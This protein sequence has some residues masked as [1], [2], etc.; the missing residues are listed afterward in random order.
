MAYSNRWVL[1]D[2][3]LNDE[4]ITIRYRDEVE[5]ELESGK[6]G[7]CV[8]ILWNADQVDSETGYPSTEELD[9]IDAFNKK[10]MTA[11]E[12]DAHGLLVM[13]LMS[14]GVNQWILY[15]RDN[16]EMQ[17][18][19]NTIPTDTGLYPIEVTTDADAQWDVFTQLR[20]AIKTH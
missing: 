8:Q 19:L 10:L 9:K 5:G 15:V 13:V 3:T 17:A 14:Q 7:Q 1:A 6:Y 18:D 2:G 4:P 20:D 11:V 12:K 16:D